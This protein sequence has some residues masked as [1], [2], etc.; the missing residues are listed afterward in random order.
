MIN[1]VKTNIASL[2]DLLRGRRIIS[3]SGESGTGKTTLALQLIASIMTQ[4]DAFD[5]QVVW[6]QASEQFPKKRLRAFFKSSN[7]KSDALLK[8][9][10]LYPTSTP[11]LS[12]EDQSFFFNT[13][14]SAVLP[15]DTKCL[16]IDNIS[17]HLRFAAS[18]YSNFR[19]RTAL[20]DEFFSSQLFPLIMR[21]LREEIVLVL[22]HEVSFD[23]A[24][25][26]NQ[27][28]FNTL[29][30]RINS[31]NVCLSKPFNFTSK[32]KR[33]EL[34]LRDKEITSELKYKILEKGLS[35]V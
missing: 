18:C 19:Q 12:Y 13:L 29:Y 21:C 8:K 25:G 26:K 33:M 5:T 28:F 17:H 14:G 23:P 9:I 24:L 3:I 1:L 31:V 4:D 20:L 6:I 10:F 34:K 32:T 16:V 27:M 7:G 35:L 11:F 15:F 30:S 22:I 2:L